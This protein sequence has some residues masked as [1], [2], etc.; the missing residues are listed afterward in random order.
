MAALMVHGV[1]VMIQYFRVI[2]QEERL[3]NGFDFRPDQL[4]LPPTSLWKELVTY[5]HDDRIA[6]FLITRHRF[7]Q[8]YQL[9]TNHYV[10]ITPLCTAYL[11]KL[12]H[13]S[14]LIWLPLIPFVALGEA[15]DMTRGAVSAGSENSQVSVGPTNK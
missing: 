15:I 10:D 3:P 8:K 12:I 13:F 5:G 9:P 14:P 7:L 2:E 4:T 1:I 6:E 11:K